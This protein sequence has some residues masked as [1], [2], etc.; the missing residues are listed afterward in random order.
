MAH[1]EKLHA[2]PSWPEVRRE[3]AHAVTEIVAPF[4]GASSPFGDDLRLPRPAD[5]LP[6]VHPF[7]RVNR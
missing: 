2:N 5:D 7:T 6:Y 1:V 3:G 4:A